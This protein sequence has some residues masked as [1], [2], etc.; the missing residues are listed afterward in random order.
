MRKI[1][2]ITLILAIPFFFAADRHK[3]TEYY[4]A[5][6]NCENFFDT[7]DDPH[8]SDNEF[9]PDAKRK[10]NSERYFK[11]VDRIAEALD[12][13]PGALPDII[14]LVEIE[15]KS[16]LE[17][18]IKNPRLQNGNY[19]ILITEGQDVRNID[20]GLLYDKTV[21]KLQ[22]VQHIS[23]TNPESAKNKT[24]DILYAHLKYWNES[25]HVFVVHWPS[26]IG[27]REETEPK[28]LYAAQQLRKKVD[29]IQKTQPNAKI[30]IM[31]DFNDTPENKSIAEI[32]KAKEKAEAADE[33]NN[34]F[35]PIYKSGEGTYYFQESWNLLDMILTSKAFVGGPHQL[36][37]DLKS[38]AVLRSKILLKQ[39]IG[40]NKIHPKKTYNSTTYLGGYSDHLPVYIKLFIN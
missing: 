7:L 6:Y 4:V 23:A 37:C 20:V 34:P 25:V 24:R 31:G 13:V 17:D 21:F 27:G 28:R 38:A 10:W 35:M 3:Y 2:R 19:D 32:L 16:C 15:S 36:S 9:L 1:L 40:K 8:K 12:S 18:L 26:R 29:S 14:G 11:K 22:Q 33:F 30:M 39:D 5:S